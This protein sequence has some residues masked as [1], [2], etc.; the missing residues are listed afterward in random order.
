MLGTLLS[1]ERID[2]ELMDQFRAEVIRPRLA[3][4]SEILRRGIARGDIR[5]DIVPEI[6]AQLLAGSI[7]A[8]HVSGMPE[9]EPWLDAVFD[10]IWDGIATR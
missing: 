9:D 8:R 4:A 1:K 7:L 6:V 2:P 5:A 3:A 10:T